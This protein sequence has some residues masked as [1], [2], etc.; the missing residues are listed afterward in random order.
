MALH[1]SGKVVGAA[2]D[3]IRVTR[4]AGKA[5]DFEDKHAEW[6]HD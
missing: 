6:M 3:E 4:A 5:Q 1:W 2:P